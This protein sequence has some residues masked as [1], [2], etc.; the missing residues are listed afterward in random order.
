MTVLFAIGLVIAMVLFFANTGC[1]TPATIARKTIT[2][3]DTV[4]GAAARIGRTWAARC[5]ADAKALGA[6]KTKFA[7][8]DAAYTRCEGVGDKMV[9]VTETVEDL[10]QTAADGI[11]A[12]EK[13]GQKDYAGVLGPALA[14]VNDLIKLFADQGLKLPAA[15]AGGK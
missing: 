1:G 12:G 14:I 10:T 4:N 2:G 15:P 3:I 7:E 6:D 9:K 11:D 8:A 5:H 13:L